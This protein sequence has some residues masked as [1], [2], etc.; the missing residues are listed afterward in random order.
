MKNSAQYTPDAQGNAVF[1]MEAPLSYGFT[2]AATYLAVTTRD[3][4]VPAGRSSIKYTNGET[5]LFF[6]ITTSFKTQCCEGYDIADKY[7]CPDIA[8]V[9]CK[10]ITV[11][12]TYGATLIFKMLANKNAITLNLNDLDTS[13]AVETN[14]YKGVELF[15][16]IVGTPGM[17]GMDGLTNAFSTSELLCLADSANP[18]TRICSTYSKYVSYLDAKQTAGTLYLY[19]Q[20]F[21][22]SESLELHTVCYSGHSDSLK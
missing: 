20:W 15:P 18:V 22:T 19:N 1:D 16:S 6:P 4:N 7:D 8:N 12:G 11:V 21:L 17:F 9:E 5:N 13:V 14:V 3:V 10:T 2:S